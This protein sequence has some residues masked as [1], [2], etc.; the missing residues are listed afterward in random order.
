MSYSLIG[1]FVD[2]KNK[3]RIV[4]AEL[5][6]MKNLNTMRYSNEFEGITATGVTK[7]EEYPDITM[8]TYTE[9]NGYYSKGVL[10]DPLLKDSFIKKNTTHRE[11]VEGFV[12]DKD[13]IEKNKETFEK[14]EQHPS[15][16][17]MVHKSDDFD[18]KYV[19]VYYRET[20]KNQGTWFK[21]SD[22]DGVEDKY[23]KEFYDRKSRVDKL[24]AMK[25]TKDWFEMSE[26]ARNNFLEELSYAEDD[27][28]DAEWKYWSIQKMNNIIDFIKEDV[29]FPYKDE[30]GST[31][32]KWN[33]DDN[34]EIEIYIEVD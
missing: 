21:A 34:R 10:E 29:G 15:F 9:F 26:D 11:G 3:K 31:R 24:N 17:E 4:S 32:Y 25:D 1:H 6:F 23:K 2:I 19:M 12:F 27:L 18:S 30:T 22:F 13:F 5:G 8:Y 16:E 7:D 28:Q 14:Y 33:Y 20:K